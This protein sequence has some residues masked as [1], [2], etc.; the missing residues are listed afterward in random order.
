MVR[1]NERHFIRGILSSFSKQLQNKNSFSTVLVSCFF[2]ACWQLFTQFPH[3]EQCNNDKYMINTNLSYE[4]LLISDFLMF[5][6]ANGSPS[7]L[8]DESTLLLTH[9]SQTKQLA[10]GHVRPVA[11][12][13]SYSS[14][15]MPP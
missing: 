5:N 8:L 1:K 9:M 14:T 3:A 15:S 4:A 6:N 7:L 2:S 11:N 12:L 13:D 10:Q